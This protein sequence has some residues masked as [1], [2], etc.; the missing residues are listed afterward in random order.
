MLP[1]RKHAELK[2]LIIRKKMDPLTITFHE[3]VMANGNR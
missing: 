3:M 2:Y 1:R